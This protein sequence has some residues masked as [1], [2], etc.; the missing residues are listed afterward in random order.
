MERPLFLSCF[1]CLNG[2]HEKTCGGAKK[3]A[4]S[5]VHP[6]LHPP[7]V[8]DRI[9]EAANLEQI[10]RERIKVN[11]KSGNLGEAVG[12]VERRK[13][14]ITLISEVTFSRKYL[15]HLTKKIFE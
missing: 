5:E 15:K 14:K 11:G 2:T 6:R 10:F 8:E 9:T 12:Y 4:G 13:C 1:P 7:S 3:E